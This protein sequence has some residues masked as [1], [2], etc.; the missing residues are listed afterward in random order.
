MSYKY[1]G[2]RGAVICDHCKTVIDADID[3]K[4]YKE[5]YGKKIGDICWRCSSKNKKKILKENLHPALN[6]KFHE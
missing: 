1:F 5:F 2:G 6:G 4:E 3:H